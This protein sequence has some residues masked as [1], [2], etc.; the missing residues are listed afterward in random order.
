[1]L[2][3]PDRISE[4]TKYILKVFDTKTHRNE[5]YDL[6]HRRLNGFNAMF[7]V[8]SVEAAKLYYEEFQKQQESLPEEKRL[9]VAT[10]YS[11]SAN[12][13]PSAI[14]EIEDENFE[15]SAMNSTAKEFLNKA[16]NDY[17]KLFKLNFS[18]EGKEF[19]NYYSD[20]SNRVKN[21]EVDL[22]IVVGMFLTGFDAPT[23]NTLFV[24]KNLR[25]H[26]LIQ[27]FSRTNRIL[28]KVKTFGNIVC[29]RNLER[30]TE[31]AIKTF[32]DENS[33]NVIL[34]KSYDEYIHGFTDEETGKK[35]KGYIDICEEIIVK[36]P[37]PTE[38]VLDADKKEFVQ[39]FGELLKAENILR[40]FDEFESFEKIISDRQMQDMKSVYVD[41]RE[42]ILNERRSKE[43]E[44]EQIDFSDV[45]FQIDLLKTD[46][47][48]LDYI[49]ALILEKTRENDDIESL[50]AEVRRVIRSSLGTRAKEDLIMEFISK[51]RLSELKNTD[52]IIETFYEFAKKEKVV[53]I[54]QLIAEENLNEKANRFI[55]KSISK[56]Y[57][58]YA[59]DELD[60][61]I[62][63]LSRRG[64]VREK[65]KEIVLEKIRKVVEVFVGI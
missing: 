52:D 58:E 37:D 1:M 36:F 34:E 29:F 42:S 26:G 3:H 11:F 39:L 50:K 13:E 4:I 17:N 23:L 51:T 41:I 59:G 62:P 54:N 31:D 12:E 30:A 55:E 43:A 9:K 63:P 24:D 35:F 33:V 7:A 46:E 32:G 27:A 10:I 25:Y 64:G 20:L 53:K 2:M 38:I 28:N 49:L 57:V 40:N 15:S 18:T 19:Q 8:Q 5:F 14:G 45:E 21:K 16:I 60:G 65:K 56:G 44:G 48:N 47:I 6:K 61:I 22:L